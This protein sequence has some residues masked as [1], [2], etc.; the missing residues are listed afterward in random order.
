VQHK[1]FFFWILLDYHADVLYASSRKMEVNDMD[2]RTQIAVVSQR[3][4]QGLY[5]MT[6]KQVIIDHPGHGRCLLSEGFGGIDTIAGGAYRW[7]HGV[8]AKLLPDDTWDTLDAWAGAISS[9]SQLI[10]VLLDGHDSDRP[11]LDWGGNTITA[12][13]RA[14]SF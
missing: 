7:Q 4:V 11:L 3:T 2:T 9:P 6:C 8:A 13:A 12:V 14:A 1:S 10:T 5:D